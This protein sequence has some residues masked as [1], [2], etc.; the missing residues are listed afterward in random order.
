MP[1][2]GGDTVANRVAKGKVLV[3]VGLVDPVDKSGPLGGA[4]GVNPVAKGAVGVERRHSLLG[5][6]RQSGEGGRGAGWS[7]TG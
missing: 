7:R 4:S 2:V 1:V 6:G 5:P 3:V